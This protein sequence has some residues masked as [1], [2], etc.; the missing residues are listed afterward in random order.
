MSALQNHQ[1]ASRWPYPWLSCRCGKRVLATT[2]AE[3][4][5]LRRGL[6]YARRR[7]LYGWGDPDKGKSGVRFGAAAAVF[8]SDVVRNHHP[9]HDSHDGGLHRKQVPATT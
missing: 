9:R 5:R 4:Q 6:E 8:A 3:L 1:I 2:P 7:L